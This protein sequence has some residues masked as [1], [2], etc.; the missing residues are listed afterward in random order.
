VRVFEHFQEMVQIVINNQ[1]INQMEP[2]SVTL[3]SDNVRLSGPT[4]FGTGE[5]DFPFSVGMPNC[6]A[7]HSGGSIRNSVKGVVAVKGRPDITGETSIGFS[8]GSPYPPQQPQPYMQPYGPQYGP[9]M[10]PQGYGPQGYGYGQPQPYGQPQ[11]QAPGYPPQQ[12]SQPQ[13]AASNS[14]CKYCQGIMQ[15]G[16]SKCPTCGAPQ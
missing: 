9:P 14:R 5:R 4:D 7:T 10:P 1:R 13:Q 11:G 3:F 2:R 12:Y 6:R 15:L 16:S 8:A